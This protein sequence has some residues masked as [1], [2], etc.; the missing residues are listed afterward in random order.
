MYCDVP[1]QSSISASRLRT[2]PFRTLPPPLFH[3]LNCS[4]IL[5]KSGFEFNQA[6]K[7]EF[8]KL[9]MPTL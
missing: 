9:P 6:N 7:V 3:L 8:E 2:N 5:G 1:S 4:G